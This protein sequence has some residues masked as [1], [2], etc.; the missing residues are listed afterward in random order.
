MDEWVFPRTRSD[1]LMFVRVCRGGRA[2][3]QAEL[4]EDVAQVPFD[5]PLADEELAGDRPVRLARG[6]LTVSR[7]PLLP[8]AL[9][10]QYFVSCYFQQETIRESVVSKHY[11]GCFCRS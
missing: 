9:R 1:Q 4:V 8:R 7:V 5:G 3:R 2:R 10:P 11:L 6:D